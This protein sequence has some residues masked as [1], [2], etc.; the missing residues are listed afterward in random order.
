MGNEWRWWSGGWFEGINDRGLDLSSAWVLAVSERD[1]GDILSLGCCLKRCWL[2]LWR[3]NWRS[4]SY[5]RLKG[6]MGLF[7]EEAG[8][9]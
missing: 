6:A 2:E 4:E 8:E 5:G 9:D 3:S 7:G 1:G